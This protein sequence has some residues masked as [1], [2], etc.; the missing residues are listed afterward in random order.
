MEFIR[1][2]K[3]EFD[4]I[5]GR[6]EQQIDA[7]SIESMFDIDEG[8]KDVI[9]DW[10]KPPEWQYSKCAGNLDWGWLLVPDSNHHFITP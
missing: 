5:F 4:E 3:C 1:A 7:L 9:G 6:S 2:N 10:N 8:L